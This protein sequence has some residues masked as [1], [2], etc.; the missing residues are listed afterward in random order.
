MAY[1]VDTWTF[2]CEV[3]LRGLLAPDL[4]P[5]LP[6]LRAQ[7]CQHAR[8]DLLLAHFPSTALPSLPFT[9]VSSH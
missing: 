7:N 6:R 1:H 3:I 8:P 5:R 2:K 9:P 4:F